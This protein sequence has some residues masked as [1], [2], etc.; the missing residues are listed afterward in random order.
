MAEFP[1][2]PRRTLRRLVALVVPV[3][4]DCLDQMTEMSFSFLEIDLDHG[5]QHVGPRLQA[6]TN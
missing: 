4:G 5:P 6:R 2:A 1:A 3:G